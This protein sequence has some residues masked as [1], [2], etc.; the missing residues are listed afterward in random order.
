MSDTKG[1]GIISLS[2]AT[3]IL[4]QFSDF[5]KPL[6]GRIGNQSFPDLPRTASAAAS[7]PLSLPQTIV[8][9]M[10]YRQPHNQSI[11][12]LHIAQ[13]IISSTASVRRVFDA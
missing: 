11:R 2:A 7:L 6:L 8:T 3:F 13:L 12:Q 9:G 5:R 1:C 10:P 4:L